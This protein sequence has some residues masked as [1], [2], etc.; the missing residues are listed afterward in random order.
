MGRIYS[1]NIDENEFVFK[2]IEELNKL[3]DDF[4]EY[5]T[6]LIY[7]NKF[8]DYNDFISD[9]K[10]ENESIINAIIK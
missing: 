6:V 1:V 9:Y 7:K 8:M 2:L 4:K 10:I 3:D 5:N